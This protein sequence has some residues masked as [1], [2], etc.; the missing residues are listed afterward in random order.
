MILYKNCSKNVVIKEDIKRDVAFFPDGNLI[1]ATSCSLHG[2]SNAMSDVN[3]QNAPAKSEGAC[4]E[5]GILSKNSKI[6]I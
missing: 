1:A 2:P 5:T 3:T 4:N 6:K